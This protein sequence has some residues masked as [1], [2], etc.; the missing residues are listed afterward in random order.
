MAQRGG[1]ILARVLSIALARSS[2]AGFMSG[3]WNAP[4]ALMTRAC[5]ARALV[6]SSHSFSMQALFPAHVKPAGKSTFA[7]WQTGSLET[8]SAA[9]ASL[10]SFSSVG[11]SRPATEHMHCGTA[12]DAPCMASAR[13]FTSFSASSKSMTPAAQMAVYS[14]KLRP[15][16]ACG[17]STT[18]FLDSR[19]TSTAAIPAMNMAGWQ[20]LVS[21]SRASGPLRH[22][23]LMLMS[24][25]RIL[26]AL[27]SMSRTA[28]RPTASLSMPTYCEPW[29]GKRMATGSFCLAFDSLRAS[30]SS[31][32]MTAGPF[33][34][35]AI[36]SFTHLMVMGSPYSIARWSG[37]ACSPCRSITLSGSAPC[38]M[39]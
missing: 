9:L 4:P 1:F 28:G 20:Y 31:T 34:N 22:R 7:I 13:S 10:Q 14:P 16:I 18:S 3:V 36:A 24:Q 32:M 33:A 26:S 39:R 11:L 35:F 37:V 12:S 25:P 29:P 19:M 21:M 6:A 2:C 17:R 27:S 5:R 23:S 15:A 30:M 38:M 8:V